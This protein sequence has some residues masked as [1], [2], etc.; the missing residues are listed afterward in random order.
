ML[1]ANS[2]DVKSYWKI[3]NEIIGKNSYT[4][5]PSYFTDDNGK[6]D[7]NPE[8]IANNFN[9]FFANIGPALADKIP[10]SH[11]HY[12]EYLSYRNPSSV[13]LN[14]VTIDETRKIIINLKDCATGWDNINKTII[15]NILNYVSVPLT[16]I[17]NL[18]ISQ[19][20]FPEELKIA[21]IKPLHKTNDKHSY[22]NYRPISLL[23]MISKVF[24][25]V[26]YNRLL[27][28]I[29]RHNIIY[30]KQF[31]FRSNHSTEMALT[32][33]ISKLAQA[34]ENNLNT[35]GI[36]LD[37][38]KAFDTINFEILL[39][40]LEMYGIRGI[41]LNWIQSYLYGRQQF[42]HYLNSNSSNLNIST[43][44]PQGS[45][46]GPFFFIMYINDLPS[47][48]SIM[49]PILYADDSNFFYNFP[50]FENPSQIVNQEL[51]KIMDWLNANKLSL[52]L[53]KSHFILFGK[54][55]NNLINL[56]L[57]GQSIEQTKSTKF[58]GYIIEDDMSWRMHVKYL[59]N[60]ISKS[61]GILRKARQT[62]YI[63]TLIQLYYSFLY[64]YLSSGIIIWGQA[65]DNVLSPLV[66]A[67][68]RAIRLIYG[69]KARVHT[70]PLFLK[71]KILPLHYI[72]LLS[73][74]SFMFKVY[75]EML[76]P[77][78]QH[79]FSKRHTISKYITRQTNTF[80]IPKT[81]TTLTKRS[82]IFQGPTEFNKLIT[83]PN[84]TLNTSIHT[85]KKHLKNIFLNELI[86]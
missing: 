51:C 41:A 86:S 66:I 35:I 3:L 11:K 65:S 84:I 14:P 48:S 47:V 1:L 44:V 56:T 85:F 33:F 30:P 21:K 6:V 18:S 76:P 27:D 7:D 34:K 57:N 67:Q 28:F 63:T 82:I 26:M 4:N 16:H 75:H 71:S 37:F 59:C 42:V 52:N 5:Y 73:V 24:E 69:E 9:K 17:V 53:K 13:Y 31:G 68:K 81:T 77:V 38:S 40:K 22:N 60:K 55:K 46:L 83:D 49:K 39:F 58:L 61:V 20:V 43:G 50:K 15:V 25:R 10:I 70:K 64:P 32:T 12:S 45:I 80:Q 62:L 36:F 23:T 79:L 19:G 8:T 78:I 72:Y 74:L 29:G 2:N 54:V